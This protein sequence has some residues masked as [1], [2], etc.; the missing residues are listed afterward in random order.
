M[1]RNARVTAIDGS[2]LSFSVDTLCVHGDTPG[3]ADLVRLLRDGLEAEGIG[4]R[5]I[6]RVVRA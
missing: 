6:D 1:I 5:S 4:V 3:A 2:E